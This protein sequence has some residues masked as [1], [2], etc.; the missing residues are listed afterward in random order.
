MNMPVTTITA[1]RQTCLGLRR[2]NI[3]WCTLVTLIKE[4]VMMGSTTAI[5]RDFIRVGLVYKQW[6][7]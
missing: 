2:G 7:A 3:V 4:A 6:P 5:C 1:L